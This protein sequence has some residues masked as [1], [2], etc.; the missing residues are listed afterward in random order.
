[1]ADGDDLV[2][3]TNQNAGRETALY[4]L[5]AASNNAF[6]VRN[7]TGHG[8]YGVGVPGGPGYGV[9]LFGQSSDYVGVY[10]LSQTGTG[11]R[12]D[13]T[14]NYGVY[15]LS[16]TGTGVRGDTT[17]NCGLYGKAGT[18]GTG[19][20][21]DADDING[22]YGQAN[23]GVGVRGHSATGPR[24]VW[25]TAPNG[26]GVRGDS[27]TEFGVLGVVTGTSSYAAGVRG[28]CND[29]TGSSAGGVVGTSLVGPGVRG[30]SAEGTVGVVGVD[31][32][33]QPGRSTGVVGVSQN[34]QGVG[35]RSPNGI[36]VIGEWAP[37]APAGGGIGVLGR[38]HPAGGRGV[39]GYSDNGYAVAGTTQT[40]FAGVF[41][42]DVLVRGNLTVTGPRKSTAVPLPDGSTRLL[43]CMEGPQPWFEDV[44][45]AELVDGRAQVA[46]DPDLAALIERDDYHV[47]L[48][49]EGDCN[50][51]FVSDR[52][53]DGFEVRELAGGT[54][55]IPFS[56]RLVAPRRD[57]PA[58][59]LPAI[60]LPSPVDPRGLLDGEI[61]AVE[62]PSSVPLA[63]DPPPDTI[64]EPPDRVPEPPAS[65]PLDDAN[66]PGPAAGD[67]GVGRG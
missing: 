32:F 56:Y 11:V 33:A 35:G 26:G 31:Q 7:N 59:R 65:V 4:R 10:G 29:G 63:F 60:E 46:L 43:F 23:T 41:E 55:T 13:T 54:G 45:R 57:A 37:A 48:T 30:I 2:L 61:P 24:G 44:G 6:F 67:E 9:G 21:G 40:G 58:D 66:S 8:I 39:V 15:G 53:P 12:G 62:L 28:H 3:G 51:L 42:G 47:F 18:G 34:G 64:P 16:Q 19:V 49:P 22:V 52:G 14:D 38:A 20:R 5:G 50:G 25:G 36:G 17:D 1:M 27:L